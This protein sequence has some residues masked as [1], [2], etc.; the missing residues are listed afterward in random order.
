MT[1]PNRL[2]HDDDDAPTAAGATTG[3]SAAAVPATESVA[4]APAKS[5]AV[6]PGKRQVTAHIDRQLFLWLKS[7]SAQSDRPMIVLFEE[8]LSEYVQRFAAQKKFGG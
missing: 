3:V 5:R 6:Y 2:I 4:R 7:I 1:K 8:A